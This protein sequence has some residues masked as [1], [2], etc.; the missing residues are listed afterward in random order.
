MIPSWQHLDHQREKVVTHLMEMMMMTMK[1]ETLLMKEIPREE[2]LLEEAIPWDP[3]QPF[4]FQCH[5]QYETT[6][7]KSGSTFQ[8][9][10]MGTPKNWR[11]SCWIA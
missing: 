7:K 4:H 2:A 11:N 10:L 6:T 1:E 3:Y 9:N 5:H 8:T